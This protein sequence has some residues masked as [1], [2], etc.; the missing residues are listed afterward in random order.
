M[1][2]GSRRSWSTHR[3]ISQPRCYL[4]SAGPGTPV[5]AQQGSVYILLKPGQDGPGSLDAWLSK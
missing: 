2:F 4:G 1:A 5:E 3:I